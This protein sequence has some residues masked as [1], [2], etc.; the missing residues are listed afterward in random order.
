MGFRHV[1]PQLVERFNAKEDPSKYMVIIKRDHSFY[2]DVIGTLLAIERK[3]S[4]H[5]S[6]RGFRGN[7]HRGTHKI[8]RCYFKI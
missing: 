3:E 2:R 1:I 4:K 8:Y 6:Y 7:L 5:L